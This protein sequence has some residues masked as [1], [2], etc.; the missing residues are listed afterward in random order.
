VGFETYLLF[1]AS[2]VV[3]VCPCCC[4]CCTAALVV[5]VCPCCCCGC[6][7]APVVAVCPCCCCGCTAAPVVAV[8]PCCCCGCTA[9]PVVA[10]CPCPCCGCAPAVDAFCST[11]STQ[12]VCS[13]DPYSR[14]ILYHCRNVNCNCY[15]QLSVFSTFLSPL[16]YSELPD[17]YP[18]WSPAVRAS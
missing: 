16:F 1:A 7:A 14:S 10:V 3:A 11:L 6:A 2:P 5:A 13:S 17:V 8:C 18:L 15:G 12:N 9:A 4:C